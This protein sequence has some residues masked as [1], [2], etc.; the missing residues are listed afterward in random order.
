[1]N[2]EL[3]VFLF[4]SRDCLENFPR[5][6]RALQTLRVKNNPLKQWHSQAQEIKP[7]RQ[8]IRKQGC[9]V[10]DNVKLFVSCFPHSRSSSL[11][12]GCHAEQAEVSLK[13]T[14]K[15]SFYYVLLRTK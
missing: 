11:T 3:H 6:S 5:C 15:E 1:M 10:K 9:C 8:T 7:T 4:E 14:D 13:Q 12:A 2:Y